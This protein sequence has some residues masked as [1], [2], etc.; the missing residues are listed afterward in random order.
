MA[1]QTV[2][3]VLDELGGTGAVA[4]ALDVPLSTV[5]TWRGRGIPASR[6]VELV[7]LARRKRKP[8][9]TF[10]VLAALPAP[11]EVRA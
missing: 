11:A 8:A 7:N 9:I 6:W 10:E 1:S 5:S 3:T 4:A 2:D